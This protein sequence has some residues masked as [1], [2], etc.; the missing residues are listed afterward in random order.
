M[1]FILWGRFLFQRV[2]VSALPVPLSIL[3]YTY[4]IK[5]MVAS[6]FLLPLFQTLHGISGFTCANFSFETSQMMFDILLGIL[7]LHVDVLLYR[8]LLLIADVDSR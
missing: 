1:N 5:I 6:V 2:A 4:R 7:D 3:R 8:L